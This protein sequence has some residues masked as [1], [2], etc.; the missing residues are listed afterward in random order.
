MKTRFTKGFKTRIVIVRNRIVYIISETLQ[1]VRFD[2][3]NFA[4]EKEKIEKFAANNPEIIPLLEKISNL[5]D[6]KEIMEDIIIDY[7]KDG[8]TRG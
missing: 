4:R 6:D 5:K 1:P 7:K 3:N 2:L 8:W